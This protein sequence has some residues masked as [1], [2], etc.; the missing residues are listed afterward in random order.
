MNNNNSL[1]LTKKIVI[2]GALCALT[3]VLGA[4]NL[5]MIPLGPVAS[6]TILQIPVIIACCLVGLPSGLCV[7]ASF[8][9]LSLVLAA[10][11]P[12]GALDPLFVNPLCSVLPRL[13]FACVAWGLWTLLKMIPKF[14]KVINAGITAFVSTL[15]HT[16]LVIGCLYIFKGAAIKEAMGGM[17]YFALMAVLLPQALL[18]AAASTIVNVA[19]FL[20][21]FVSEGK[22]SK[23]SSMKD[24]E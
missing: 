18:E 9:I 21:L 10:T 14:P 24:E 15:F 17:G 5:G 12:T 16:V 7:G 20:G 19:V 13:L 3:I 22:K 8:G 6:V 11:R 4:T 23:I 1:S 2:T